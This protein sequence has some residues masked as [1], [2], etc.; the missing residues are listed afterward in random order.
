MPSTEQ[1][2]GLEGSKRGGDPD[3]P[4]LPPQVCP[5]QALSLAF[6]VWDS[7]SSLQASV[8][9]SLWTKGGLHLHR[10]KEIRDHWSICPQIHWRPEQSEVTLAES[11]CWT[12]DTAVLHIYVG[13]YV[14]SQCAAVCWCVQ[15]YTG[16]CVPMCGMCACFYLCG[17]G[18]MYFHTAWWEQNF[19]CLLVLAETERSKATNQPISCSP[20]L[21]SQQNLRGDLLETTYY[22]LLKTWLCKAPWGWEDDLD[23]STSNIWVQLAN[24]EIAPMALDRVDIWRVSK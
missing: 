9:W 11:G 7:R 24:Q 17:S 6:R 4:P 20:C 21:F 3:P 10:S 1:F 19:L 2:C 13:W 22:H 18:T 12:L 8:C 15:V 16:I 23:C 14:C 5:D